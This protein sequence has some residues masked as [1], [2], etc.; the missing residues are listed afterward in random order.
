MSAL[1][2]PFHFTTTFLVALGAFAG[3]WL[4][5]SRPD[6]S[7]KGWARL[8]F[9]LGWA[10]LAAAET[11]HG[12]QILT[13]DV[14]GRLLALRSGAYL[15]L[16]VSLAAPLERGGATG[17]GPP[18]EAGDGS[19][20]GRRQNGGGTR[21]AVPRAGVPRRT[22]S[23]PQRGPRSLTPGAGRADGPE[24]SPQRSVPRRGLWATGAFA[25]TR[26]AA[27]AVLAL[28]AGV[29]AARSRL[30]GARR[31]ATA[32]ILL[33]ASEVLL[34]NGGA[35][36]ERADFLWFA[37]HGL[38]LLGGLALGVWLWRPFGFSIQARFVAAAVPLL[39]IAFPLISPPVTWVFG[40]CVRG[41]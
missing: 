26:A 36:S 30:E 13:S 39:V 7:P 14:D 41:V 38:H 35:A 28:G 27:P 1:S 24:W 10:L 9:G 34:V 11:I 40:G 33:G 3:V 25:V 17:G 4:A 32:L 15:L 31:L 23:A 37:A 18:G 16:L 5:V 6:F 29:I 2:V 21:G 8:A 19:P 20:A 22:P 12:A